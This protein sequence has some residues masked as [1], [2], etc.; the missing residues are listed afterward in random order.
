M[1]KKV[2]IICIFLGLLSKSR[3]RIIFFFNIPPKNELF[4]VFKKVQTFSSS[5]CMLSVVPN[6]WCNIRRL[7]LPCTFATLRHNHFV[8]PAHGSMISSRWIPINLADFYSQLSLLHH[9]D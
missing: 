9:P 6:K 7:V 2:I 3:D 1:I 8:H 5:A 4:I